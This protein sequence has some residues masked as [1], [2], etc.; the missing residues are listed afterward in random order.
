VPSVTKEKLTQI[1][2]YFHISILLLIVDTDVPIC[3]DGAKI[4]IFF[5]TTK[6]K[7]KKKQTLPKKK[8]SLRPKH[9]EKYNY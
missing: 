1:L 5:E 3:D 7:A 9:Y 4:R 8:K 6:K 2:C